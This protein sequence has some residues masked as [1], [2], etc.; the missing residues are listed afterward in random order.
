MKRREA[1]ATDIQAQEQ[2]IQWLHDIADE[3]IRHDYHQADAIRCDTGRGKV[4]GC[5]ALS[6]YS[7]M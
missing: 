7:E 6:C 4:T 5:F 3:L 2:R 1:I